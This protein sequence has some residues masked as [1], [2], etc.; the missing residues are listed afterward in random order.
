LSELI[1][2]VVSV[3]DAAARYKDI[4]KL[5]QRCLDAYILTLIIGHAFEIGQA[6]SY[7]CYEM[8]FTQS[9][10]YVYL[11]IPQLKSN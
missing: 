10:V 8:H 1:E 9:N 5:T 4:D 3:A 2:K 11:H 6:L 7:K